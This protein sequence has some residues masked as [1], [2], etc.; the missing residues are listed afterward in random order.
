[1][2]GCFCPSNQG[3]FS[4]AARPRAIPHMIH[5][6]SRMVGDGV[7]GAV[8]RT[9]AALRLR[10]FGQRAQEDRH[11]TERGKSICGSGFHRPEPACSTSISRR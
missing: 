11:R 3:A 8:V 1:M 6:I 2:V 10:L 5:R 4:H 7:W 9:A